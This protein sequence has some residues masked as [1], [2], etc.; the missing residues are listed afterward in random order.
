MVRWATVRTP[1][2]PNP[3]SSTDAPAEVEP[4]A[5]E[6]AY[7]VDSTTPEADAG[8]DEEGVPWRRPGDRA[9]SRIARPPA[10]PMPTARGAARRQKG[11]V[12]LVA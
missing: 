4:P 10:T 5:G 2:T 8:S 6:N 12:A 11:I 3:E 7:S 9:A 1:S